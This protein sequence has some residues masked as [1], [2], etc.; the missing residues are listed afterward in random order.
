MLVALRPPLRFEG[1][2]PAPAPHGEFSFL[3]RRFTPRTVFMEVGAADCTLALQAASYVERVYAVDVS[4]QFIHNVLMPCN[5]R[6]VLCDGVH[7]PVPETSVDVAW[8]GA[9]MDQLDPDEAHEHLRSVRRCLA[10]GGEYLCRTRG[11]P[12]ELAQRLLA[13]GFSAVRL[14]AGNARV[15]FS[16]ARLLP[17]RTLRYAA[18]R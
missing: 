18:L 6:L 7:I 14:Y 12:R 16:T 11:A 15:P 4:G 1:R 9:F 10:P 3:E 2:R 17:Y 13:A 5:L 8:T